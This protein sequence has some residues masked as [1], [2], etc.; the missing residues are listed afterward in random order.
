MH[1]ADLM[2]RVL[3]LMQAIISCSALTYLQLTDRFYPSEWQPDNG[4]RVGDY[5]SLLYFTVADV[6]ILASQWINM[7]LLH[8]SV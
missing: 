2:W 5:C 1:A 6:P 4:L 3:L 7:M 8:A